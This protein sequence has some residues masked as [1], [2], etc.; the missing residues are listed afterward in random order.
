M[1]RFGVDAEPG[2]PETLTVEEERIDQQVIGLTN[3]DDNTI[4]IYLSQPVVSDA[5][6]EALQEVIKKKN[7]VQQAVIK[8]QQLEQQVA[9]IGQEHIPG[10]M[11]AHALG[12]R[13]G[14]LV[15]RLRQDHHELVAAESGDH[16]GF[17][18]GAP[19]D[20]GRLHQGAAPQDMAVRIIDLLEAVEI[21]EQQ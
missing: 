2:E 20:R 5:I 10:H 17:A 21:D 16:I 15:V 4:R 14:A 11:R 18:R 19:D 1:Y 6:K 8:R 7:A 13:V 9:V 12:H 3:I